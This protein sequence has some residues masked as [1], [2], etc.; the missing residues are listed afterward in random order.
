LELEEEPDDIGKDMGMGIDLIILA[1]D[2]APELGTFAESEAE[3]SMVISPLGAEEVE[4]VEPPDENILVGTA[5]II[6]GSIL[7]APGGPYC[8]TV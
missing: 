3:L 2:P 6:P 4:V 1:L 7:S 5:E 8:E